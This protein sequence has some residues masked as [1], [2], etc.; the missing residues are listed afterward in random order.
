MAE[1]LLGEIWG[2]EEKPEG[3]SPESFARAERSLRQ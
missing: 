3:E 2:R 1:G